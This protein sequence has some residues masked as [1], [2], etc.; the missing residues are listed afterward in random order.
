MSKLTKLINNPSL[1]FRDFF[2]KRLGNKKGAGSSQK[3]KPVKKVAPKAPAKVDL[4]ISCVNIYKKIV[5]IIHTGEGMTHGPSHLNMW[6][7]HFLKNGN[8]FMVLVRNQALFDWVK[9]NHPYVDVAYARRPIDVEDLLM[10]L[11]YVKAFY[12]L[13][14]T[15][16]LIHSLRYNNYKHIFL[17][18]GDSDKAASAHKFFRVYDEIWVAGQA[19]IDRFKNANFETKHMKFVK[20]GRPNML[21][22][23]LASDTPWENRFPD[24]RVLY[25]PTWEG[26]YE[27]NNYSS[28]RLSVVMLSEL[29]KKFGVY[30]SVK[31]HP[32]TGSRNKLLEN[33]DTEVSKALAEVGTNFY[34]ASKEDDLSR[35]I[36]DSNV[37]IC[38]I[39]AVVSECIAANGP[40]F[41]YIP[42]DKEIVKSNSNL[43]Y[44]DY[45]YVFSSIDELFMLF[46][47]VV[48]KGDDYLA[49]ERLKARDYLLSVNETRECMFSSQLQELSGDNF[50]YVVER[51]DVV[52]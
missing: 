41:V 19:H 22:A 9:K 24:V 35:L 13:S 4:D 52:Q 50:S 15:G 12:Y 25:L 39:S 36:I 20:V 42:S 1:F 23:L 44:S 33:I 38:D 37:F 10:Q 18:H 7:P 29:Q 21:E 32:V 48:I 26:V 43:D 2:D 30:L 5:H 49:E 3:S 46:E 27:E 17:G 8:D 14:N 11:A 40:I 45:A 28:A 16:N 34:V 51:E 31:F 47:Q 6:I